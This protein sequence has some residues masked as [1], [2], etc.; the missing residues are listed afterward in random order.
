MKVTISSYSLR[1]EW[2]DLADDKIDTLIAICKDMGINAVELL[3]SEWTPETLPDIVK[4]MAQEG[5][6]VFGLAVGTSILGMKDTMQENINEGLDTIRLAHKAGVKYIRF[7]A[8][9][10]SLPAC[11]PPMDDFDDEEWEEYREQMKEAADYALQCVNPWVKLAE[12]LDI[13]CG[14]ETHHGYSS[15]YIFQD[16]LNK[17]V[18]SKHLGWIFDIGNFPDDESRYKS[19]DVIKNR[20]YYLHAKAY[21]FDENGFETKLDYPK[22][23]QIL[24]DAGFDGNWSIEFEGKMNGIYGVQ[25]LNELIRY[26]IAKVEGN[27]YS[28]N[29]NIPNGEKLIEKYQKLL[30]LV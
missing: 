11:F 29:V 23:C 22:V 20:V 10:G 21:E 2:K 27:E 13:Y 26:S 5:I 16:E 6:D 8:Q 19:L 1:N 12:E 24:K 14:V 3:E 4:K 9:G 28:M 30:G 25:K 15:N 18:S 7:F 17:L